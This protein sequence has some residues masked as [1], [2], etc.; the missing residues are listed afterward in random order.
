MD[1]NTKQFESK[2]TPEELATHKALSQKMAPG[3]IFK[4][5]SYGFS[6]SGDIEEL[7]LLSESS[8]LYVSL[9][10]K[11]LMLLQVLKRKGVAFKDIQAHLWNKAKQAGLWPAGAKVMHVSRFEWYVQMDRFNS[12]VWRNFKNYG[13]PIPTN[14]GRQVKKEKPKEVIV[15]REAK[16]QEPIAPATLPPKVAPANIPAIESQSTVHVATSTPHDREDAI[17]F[18]EAT[19]APP[20]AGIFDKLMDSLTPLQIQTLVFKNLSIL[21][22]KALELGAATEFNLLMEAMGLEH[23]MIAESVVMESV[24]EQVNA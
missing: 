13:E 9:K 22:A 15:R 1:L 16:K 23:E 6:Y 21:G 19:L 18:P 17:V 11:R 2:L 7:R 24:L 10:Q 12:W 3:H 20:S 4:D 5:D 8:T 14:P